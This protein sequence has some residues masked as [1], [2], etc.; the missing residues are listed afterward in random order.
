[1]LDAT[2][3]FN[4]DVFSGWGLV[5][6]TD[7]MA[8]RPTALTIGVSTGEYNRAI[9]ISDPNLGLMFMIPLEYIE[10]SLETHLE[11]TEENK[12]KKQKNRR[13]K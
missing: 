2:A 7:S 13:A 12:S 10:G 4:M 9:S 11:E 5:I 1:M 8:V 6:D 3:Q